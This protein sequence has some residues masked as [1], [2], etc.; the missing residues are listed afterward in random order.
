MC[1]TCEILFRSEID[2]KLESL[3]CTEEREVVA[4]VVHLFGDLED[5]LSSI[6]VAVGV[7]QGN[8]T[9]REQNA[10]NVEIREVTQ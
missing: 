4:G 8:I 10:I 3:A 2:E 6:T 5:V 1:Q 7:V 9:P